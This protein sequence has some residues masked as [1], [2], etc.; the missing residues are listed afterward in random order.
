MFTTDSAVALTIIIRQEFLSHLRRK[1]RTPIYQALIDGR[2]VHGKVVCLD[3]AIIVCHGEVSNPFEVRGVGIIS[4]IAKRIFGAGLLFGYFEPSGGVGVT[5]GR[6]SDS[7]RSAVLRHG[8]H[9]KTKGEGKGKK[10]K[11]HKEKIVSMFA[12]PFQLGPS[13]CMEEVREGITK[14]TREVYKIRMLR[15]K[16][17]TPRI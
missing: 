15:T 8:A 13:C 14:V 6:I 17:I 5:A 1:C 3:F 10:D 7:V 2:A 9:C 16:I 12:Q 11:T 4:R